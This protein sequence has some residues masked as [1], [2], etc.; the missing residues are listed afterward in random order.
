MYLLSTETEI[1]DRPRRGRNRGAV[2]VEALLM[3]GLR[4]MCRNPA[5]Q[6]VLQLALARLVAP[7]HLCIS[8]ETAIQVL[9]QQLE[10]KIIK[11]IIPR[12][13]N[14]VG[15]LSYSPPE[16]GRHLAHFEYASVVVLQSCHSV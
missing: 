5:M 8:F 15:A 3:T 11:F 1:F 13:P 14:T 6:L 16:D 12:L 2:A 4:G 7:C 10:A 9:L